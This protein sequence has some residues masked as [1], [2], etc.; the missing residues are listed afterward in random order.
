MLNNKYGTSNLLIR[1]TMIANTNTT[2]GTIATV[3]GTS[4]IPGTHIVKD[5]C[6]VIFKHINDV[7]EPVFTIKGYQMLGEKK[8]TKKLTNREKL[9]YENIE[10]IIFNK[11]ATIIIFKDGTKEVVKCYDEDFDEEKGVAM[12]ML[13]LVFDNNKS[14]RKRFIDKFIVEDKDIKK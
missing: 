1:E 12:I 3:S 10:K 13:N 4:Y 14:E 8:K 11:P 9:N 2:T 5:D 7:I 6:D